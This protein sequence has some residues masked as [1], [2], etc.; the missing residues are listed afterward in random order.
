M[1]LT[2]RATTSSTFHPDPDTDA[3]AD[4]DTESS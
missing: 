2:I 4:I 3:D 1:D